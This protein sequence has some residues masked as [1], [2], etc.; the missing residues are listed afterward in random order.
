MSR[1][2]IKDIESLTG[3]KAHTL[4]IWE[5][6]YD[7]LKPK[8]T[9]TN[10]RYFDDE[11]LKTLLNVSLLN[12]NGVKISKI[13]KL[14]PEE[15]DELIL[16]ITAESND[17]SL[18]MHQLIKC[19]LQLD[20]MAFEQLLRNHISVYGITKTMTDLIFPFMNHIGVM[21]MSGSVNPAYEHFITNLIR[22]KLILA[23][24]A[25]GYKNMNGYGKRFL[26]F[27]PKDEHHEIG[28]L[29]ANY[30]IRS[31]GHH[32]MYLGQDLP[33][34]DLYPVIE[35]YK[36]D[37][38]FTSLTTALNPKFLKKFIEFVASVNFPVLLAGRT[39]LS[40]GVQLPSNVI[41]INST[42][43]LSNVLG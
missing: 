38:I 32:T 4:R 25:L 37:Y 31:A 23:S 34:E 9:D 18:Q 10:I 39:L 7:F 41:Y 26:L 24:D 6:R 21:W 36:P 5:Q 43:D 12:K 1:F 35:T 28:L 13:A 22:S 20:E 2:S 15:I 11:D 16:E 14:T 8:R 29:F 40:T 30:L 17:I 27:L 3:V 33:C 19:M 42:Q